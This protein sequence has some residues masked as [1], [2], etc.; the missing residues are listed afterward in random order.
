MKRKLYAGIVLAFLAT[1]VT[2]ASVQADI[3]CTVS[4]A[5]TISDVSAMK[6]SHNHA[7]ICW[8]TDGKA[9]SRVFYDT[10]S[11]NNTADYAY[12]TG[13]R[14]A[15]VKEHKIALNR[16][17]TSV[18]YYYRV[19]SAAGSAE[20]VSDEYTFTTVSSLRGLT[21]WLSNMFPEYVFPFHLSWLR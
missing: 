19:R 8:S 6:I 12:Y 11:H 9:T 15:L 16:L 3:V 2:S 1:L 10:V 17:S 7:T 5:L 4:V 14:K 21:A 20:F 13:E 18:T